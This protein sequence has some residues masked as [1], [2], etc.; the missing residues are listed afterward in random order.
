MRCPMAGETIR[1]CAIPIRART[2]ILSA[3]LLAVATATISAG[4]ASPAI[5]PHRALW[6]DPI[7]SPAGFDRASRAEI[8]VFAH[9]LAG[10]DAFNEGALTDRLGIDALDMPSVDR[11]RRRLWKLLAGNYAMA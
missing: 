9:E 2:I 6:P 5:L 11:L 10:S 3:F 8:L 7:D 4:D 1:I